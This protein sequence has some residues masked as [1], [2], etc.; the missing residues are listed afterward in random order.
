MLEAT[1]IL[2]T[3]LF[4]L[5]W[6]LWIGF[7]LMGGEFDWCYLHLV[8]PA[9]VAA[10]G[11]GRLRQRRFNRMQPPEPG[12]DRTGRIVSH[13][14]TRQVSE[15]GP[16]GGLAQPPQQPGAERETP[17]LNRMRNWTCSGC[18][19]MRGLPGPQHCERCGKVTQTVWRT[20]EPRA[21]KRNIQHRLW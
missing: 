21:E 8:V 5:A 12:P 20:I 9:I 18:R 7:L 10:W 4:V 15:T 11:A 16:G 13:S 14:G 2:L 19:K 17:I 3:W 6:W 1:L